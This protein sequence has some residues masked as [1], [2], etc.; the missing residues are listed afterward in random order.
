MKRMIEKLKQIRKDDWMHFTVSLVVSW[1][2]AVA[3][4]MVFPCGVKYL[5]SAASVGFV[6]SVGIG[7][8]KEFTDTIFSLADL[9]AD[10]IGAIVGVTMFLIDNL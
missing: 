2:V 8:W 3:C 9:R 6:C 1:A 7:V 4:S 10:I 5:V